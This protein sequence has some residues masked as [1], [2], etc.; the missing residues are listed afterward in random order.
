MPSLKAQLY[1]AAAANSGLTALLGTPPR[2]FDEQLEQGSTFPA[3]TVTMISNPQDYSLLGPLATSWVR[4]QFSIYGAGND[5]E[6][7]N[8]VADALFS[9]IQTFDAL[10]LPNSPSRPNYVVGDRDF[11]I[12]QT[13]PLTYMRIVDYQLFVNSQF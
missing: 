9:F 10:G 7:A 11:G 1:T 3:V 2:W 6:N 12:A 8:A 5:S 13:N 4:V